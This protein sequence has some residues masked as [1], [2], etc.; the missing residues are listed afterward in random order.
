MKTGTEGRPVH[1]DYADAHLH[2]ERR[3]EESP[4]AQAVNAGAH[5]GSRADADSRDEYE[6]Q[7]T[8]AEQAGGERISLL[9]V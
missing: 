2:R 6:R 8:V 1:H 7:A 9:A 5:H 4:R 3:W